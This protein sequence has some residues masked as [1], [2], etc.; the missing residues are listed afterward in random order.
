[1]NDTVFYYVIPDEDPDNKHMNVIVF[2][3]EYEIENEEIMGDGIPQNIDELRKH[4]KD[5]GE[6]CEDYIIHT[7]MEKNEICK[8]LDKLE[9]QYAHDAE[10]CMWC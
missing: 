8:A 3:S 9:C 6:F 4:F 10:D 1:M 7:A 2:C 5:T